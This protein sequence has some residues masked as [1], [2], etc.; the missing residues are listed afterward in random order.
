[1]TALAIILIVLVTVAPL[2]LQRFLPA[3]PPTPTTDWRP[4]ESVITLRSPAQADALIVASIER[5][6]ASRTKSDSLRVKVIDLIARHPER[7]AEI[8]RG[9][10]NQG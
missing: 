10:L 5:R 4:S 6:D 7:G 9:W 3:V 8:V 2:I 1:M